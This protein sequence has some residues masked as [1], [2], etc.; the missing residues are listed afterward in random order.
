MSH[1]FW[2]RILRPTVEVDVR[3]CLGGLVIHIHGLDRPSKSILLG[4]NTP[5]VP[6]LV[7][8]LQN[9]APTTK[10]DITHQSF[11]KNQSFYEKTF[12]LGPLVDLTT[13]L[14]YVAVE[15]AWNPRGPHLSAWPRRAHSLFSSSPLSHILLSSLRQ[16]GRRLGRRPPGRGR[17]AGGGG[18]CG[19][20]CEPGWRSRGRST[21]H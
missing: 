10:P 16:A 11:Y 1:I 13:V 15:S 7:I 21:T 2:P 20:R 8:E 14:F 6:Q 17:R 3:V 5:E 12:T 9:R 19:G 18:G 4:K